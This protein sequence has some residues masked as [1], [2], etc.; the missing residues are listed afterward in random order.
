MRRRVL[1]RCLL[2]STVVVALVA[3]PGA[4][5]AGAASLSGGAE[6]T[7]Q[8]SPPLVLAVPGEDEPCDLDPLDIDVDP[9]GTS[10]AGTLDV[11]SFTGSA[12]F[13]EPASNVW[14]EADLAVLYSDLTY[15][16][17]PSPPN[18]YDVTGTLALQIDLWTVDAGGDEPSCDILAL[19]CT[20]ALVVEVTGEIDG[21]S[22]PLPGAT[23]L[24]LTLH[25]TT[26][27]GLGVPITYMSGDCDAEVL[28]YVESQV[29]IVVGAGRTRLYYAWTSALN[30]ATCRIVVKEGNAQVV[31][32]NLAKDDEQRYNGTED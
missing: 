15:A 16:A 26:D 25:G 12:V 28:A 13:E 6:L 31:D 14:Y 3:L 21:G 9:D 30:I 27:S 19:A 20:L 18:V 8:G 22:S 32:T 7:I 17:A 1:W 2:A 11:T 4:S 5:P 29:D 10:T 23:D 24:G